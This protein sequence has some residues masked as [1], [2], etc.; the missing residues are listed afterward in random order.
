M[1]EFLSQN[2]LILPETIVE[3]GWL[4]HAP[5]AFHLISALDPK[6]FVELG[7]HNGF[8]YFCFCQAIKKHDLRTKS[9]AVD[10]WV[11]DEHAG[12]YEESVF[13]SVSRINERYSG[14]SQLVRS[15]FSEAVTQFTDGYIDLLHIDGRHF[16]EDAKSDFEEWLPKLSPNAI[17]LFH[18]TEVREREFGVWKLFGEL[19][20]KYPS[21]NFHH[22]HGLGVLALGE[23]PECLV[24]FMNGDDARA[25][26]I[27]R[28]YSMLGDK[29]V[30][31]WNALIVEADR[32]ALRVETTDQRRKLSDLEV[33][34]NEASELSDRRG[35]QIDDLLHQISSLAALVDQY[36]GELQ[37][38]RSRETQARTER[39][40]SLL[41]VLVSELQRPKLRALRWKASVRHPLSGRKRRKY[42]QKKREKIL[43][44]LNAS[45]TAD[46][47]SPSQSAQEAVNRRKLRY[48][49]LYRH[50]FNAK[51]RRAYRQIRIERADSF[52]QTA[53]V[54]IPEPQPEKVCS[55]RPVSRTPR[56]WFYVGDTVDWLKAHQRLT[57]V[58]RVSVEILSAA[59]REEHVDFAPCRTG[60]SDLDLIGMSRAELDADLLGKLDSSYR[61]AASKFSADGAPSKGDH[62]F[63]TGLVW[64]PKFTALFRHLYQTGIGFSVL[65]HDIIPLEGGADV[66][67]PQSTRFAEWL[68]V[69]LQ[70]ADRVFVSTEYVRAQILRWAVLEGIEVAAEIVKIPFGAHP[71]KQIAAP[72][73]LLQQDKFTRVQV[74]DF[75]LSVGTVDARK[76]QV[77]LCRLWRMLTKSGY[78][79]PQLVLAGRNDAGLGSEDSVYRDLAEKGKLVVLSGL[80][81]EEIAVLTRACRFT[82]FPSLSEGYG[83]PV[84]ESLQQGKLCLASNLPP[85]ME[86]AS[87]LVWYFDPNDI[88][89][90]VE[91]FT[92]ALT[93]YDAVAAAEGKIRREFFRPT[94]S[95]A[96]DTLRSEGLK[97]A[98][99]RPVPVSPGRYRPSYPGAAQFITAQV[100]E[101]AARWCTNDNPEVSIL[102][103]NWNAAPLTLE[104]IRQIWLNTEGHTYE[105][106]IVDNGS[107]E[108][109]IERLSRPIPGVTFIKIGCNRFFGEANNIAAEAASG[110]YVVLLNNDAFPQSGWLA[111]MLQMM[112]DNPALGAVGP[113]FLW[114]NG[115]VQE[116]GGTINEGG[117]PVRYGRDQ[118]FPTQDILSEKFVDYISAAALLI[119]RE[120]FMKA[121]GFDLI[122]EPAYYED[123]DLCFKLRALGRPVAYCPES[124]VIHIEGAAANGNT[125]A[126]VRRKALGD[127]NRDKFVA[128][129]GEFLRE[130]D[131]AVLSEKLA[132][133][134][135]DDWSLPPKESED[136]PVAVVFSPYSVTPG[137]GERYLLSAARQ[138][139]RTHRV[140]VV[141]PYPY[142]DLRLRQIGSAFEIDLGMLSFKTLAEF[143]KGPDP[144]IMLTMGNAALPPVAGRGRVRIY[145]CQFPFQ[146]KENAESD[147][148]MLQTYQ[149]VMVNSSYTEE[150]YRSRC[151]KA[152]LPVLPTQIVYPPVPLIEPA[153][154][155]RRMIF[156]V[157]RFFVGG[158]S[159]RQ[160]LQIE[161]F[162]KLVEGGMSDVELHLAGSSSPEPSDIDF[163][164]SIRETAADLPVFFHINCPIARLKQLYA[165]SLVYWHATGLGRDLEVE[166][167]K[168]EHFGISLV[169]AMSGGAIPVALRAGGPTEIITDGVNGFFYDDIAGL[170]DQTRRIM[171]DISE[172]ELQRLSL[173]AHSRALD[174]SYSRFNDA[175]SSLFGQQ[176]S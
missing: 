152:G 124:R 10:T 163:L 140:E 31:E 117:Y 72:E 122:F 103:V 2:S 95:D 6:V 121:A 68:T 101:R 16:Y 3:S 49:A 52:L 84:V 153:K 168:A 159:K 166:P 39:M 104:C 92:R 7:T 43:R 27:R 32:E 154:S 79:M 118:E 147:G 61:D 172:G 162:R 138:L 165:E 28:A 106:V 131:D 142:S 133:F 73:K 23:V 69:A 94:W 14:F 102:I 15:T 148:A 156:S 64:T 33:A 89:G 87:D 30:R 65:V 116:A 99:S 157:G 132:D 113:M 18:D 19:S 77:L 167:E 88:E 93:D 83:L 8:S 134:M 160:D 46:S 50:P 86:Q 67:E 105:V 141:T 21:F 12:F 40:S 70:T 25:T 58:G 62:V 164:A 80:D 137:G 119:D 100:L 176:L 136:L 115:R 60:R 126:E 127:S 34:L 171:N 44:R 66:D 135:P 112:N 5:F 90:A 20:E 45:R 17:V 63:F 11:G 110:K 78:D 97:A 41:D 4:G 170:V 56:L 47:V 53:V 57:G 169:E 76:N 143:K 29:V 81:D 59:L 146:L 120:M 51:K 107:G 9:F 173:A 125:E 175:I 109:D 158:H 149:K 144:D 55:S 128:R 114:P 123:T 1:Q 150:N 71:L 130:R 108:D 24:P 96:V 111:A 91:V 35:Q 75:V 74:D 36:S 37:Q 98:G 129:W 48:T 85:V 13:E 26:A 139:A 174:F 82:A 22:Q 38:S 151:K 145:H 42:R 161:S 155:K 54:P